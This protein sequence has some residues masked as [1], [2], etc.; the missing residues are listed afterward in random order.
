MENDLDLLSCPFLRLIGAAVPGPDRPGAVLAQWGHPLERGVLE[1]V[2]RGNGPCSDSRP[3][4]VLGLPEGVTARAGGSVTASAALPFA[5]VHDQPLALAALRP[6]PDG[7]LKPLRLT[8]PAIRTLPGITRLHPDTGASPHQSG[9]FTRELVGPGAGGGGA[10]HDRLPEAA[11]NH[12]AATPAVSS[13]GARGVLPSRASRSR[14]DRVVLSTVSGFRLI[15]SMPIWTRYS[16]M[17]G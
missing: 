9:T 2:I 10:T 12:G 13:A 7:A 8:L 1:W 5:A 6:W 3:P 4:A 16:A 15:E 11:Q 17:S 14:T